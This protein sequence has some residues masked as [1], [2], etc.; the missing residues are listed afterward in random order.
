MTENLVLQERT[1]PVMVLTMNRPDKH[2]ALN[3][4]MRCAFLGALNA[5]AADPDVRVLVLT[6]AGP[7]AFVSGADIAEMAD[8]TPLEQRRVMAGP[9]IYEALW[10]LPKPVVAA[11]NGYC[12]GGGLELA[13]ACDIRV[14]STAARFGQPEIALGLIPGGGATQRLP[15]I[16]GSGAAA[17]L[18]F[19]GDPIDAVEAHRL[20]LIDELVPPDELIVRA[21][22]L[23]GR[24]AT[25]SPVAL[26]AAK[27]ALRTALS[28]PMAAG[29]RAEATLFQL[30]FASADGSEGM[31]AFREKRLPT[32]SG[33]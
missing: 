9:S 29:L 11:I 22:A 8:R 17:R 32:F 4:A 31:K 3:G 30:C 6:G 16:I 1:G 10:S 19:T 27:D 28:T 15:R 18:I 7:K 21:L 2:N 23:A 20:G 14:A 5:A 12:L 33:T 24:I 26:A 13:M 25:R